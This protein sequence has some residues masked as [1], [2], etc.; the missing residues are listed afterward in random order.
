MARQV[1]GLINVALPTT[2]FGTWLNEFKQ[3]KPIKNERTK[4]SNG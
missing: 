3:Q 1:V 4:T 2:I